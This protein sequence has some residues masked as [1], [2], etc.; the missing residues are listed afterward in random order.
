[1]GHR[2]LLGVTGGIAAYK[3]CDVASGLKNCGFEVR[4]IMTKAAHNFVT[5]RALST[6]TGKPVLD[7]MWVD[8]GTVPHIDLA[9]WCATGMYVI[10]PATLD[11]ISDMAHGK[12]D[13]LVTAV[14]SAIPYYYD[15][16]KPRPI[17]VVCPAMNTHMW[18]SPACCT[19]LNL[20]C[21][22]G[23]NIIEPVS[24]MLACGDVG[25]GRLPPTRELVKRLKGIWNDEKPSCSI[26]RGM[27]EGDNPKLQTVSSTG[28]D[29]YKT[30]LSVVISF[31]DKVLMWKSSHDL[32]TFPSVPIVGTPAES[33][34]AFLRDVFQMNVGVDKTK[35]IGPVCTTINPRK[36]VELVTF[37]AVELSS[38]EVVSCS[39]ETEHT[40]WVDMEWF[41][42]GPELPEHVYHSIVYAYVGM[43]WSLKQWRDRREET[44]E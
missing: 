18:Q 9:K 3:A 41:D 36:P 34:L 6:I 29:G 14:Y 35:V 12:A 44:K 30:K 31:K 24:G 39:E 25:Q 43:M 38:S 7:S 11:T 32:L 28:S 16:G 4:A 19:A 8:D 27:P 22:S 2:I 23:V 26:S 15:A 40:K 17:I 37:V 21:S 33:T 1:M 13:K 42:R 10:V 5:Q 20:L